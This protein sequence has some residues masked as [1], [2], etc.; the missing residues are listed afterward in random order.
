MASSPAELTLATSKFPYRPIN[1]PDSIRLIHLLPASSTEDEVQCEL[2]HT[3]LM[4]CADIYEH[5]TA[6]SYVWGNPFNTKRV[7]VDRTPVLVTHNLH[8]VLKDLRHQTRTLQIW[9]DA[10]CINQRDDEEK[11]KQIS[12]T[13]RIYSLA[14]HT[15][16]YLEL[17]R[18][19]DA[20][21]FDLWVSSNFDGSQFNTEVADLVLSHT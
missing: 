18:L 6:L 15:V 4:D 8:S 17:S 9:A 19:Q 16:I 14:D 7:W 3:T 5:Y 13:G 12:M 20:A 10:I 21:K 2:V 11:L 1:E